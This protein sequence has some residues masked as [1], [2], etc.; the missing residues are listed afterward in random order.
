MLRSTRVFGVKKI[1]LRI[2]DLFAKIN[3]RCILNSTITGIKAMNMLYNA[4]II[5]RGLDLH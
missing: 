5:L 4:T 2:I 3:N 1:Q